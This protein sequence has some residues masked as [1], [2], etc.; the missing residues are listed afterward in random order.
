MII[1]GI[2]FVLAIISDLLTKAQ[3]EKVL[4]TVSRVDV[5]PGFF[6]CFPLLA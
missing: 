1:E 4:S 5:F 3:A 6:S 2:V